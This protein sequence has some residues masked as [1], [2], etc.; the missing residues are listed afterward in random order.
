[1]IV[2][3]FII[4]LILTSCSSDNGL[5]DIPI[6]NGTVGGE[7]WEYKF[8]NAFLDVR[9]SVFR[10]TFL[11]TEETADDACTVAATG[12]RHL[13]IDLPDVVGNY[14]LP[15]NGQSLTF[16]LEGTITQFEATSGF[17]EIT[18]VIGN[19]ITGFMQAQFDDDNKVEGQFRVK[20]CN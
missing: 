3:S 17:V 4:L 14:N 5:D 18:Q 20:V 9:G 10:I 12:L 15:N 7:A 13:T 1:M 19:Q 11:S 6:L 2:R 16:H 8:G